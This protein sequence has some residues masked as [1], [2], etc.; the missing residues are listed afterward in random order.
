MLL[1]FIS[2]NVNGLR[3]LMKKPGWDW[4]LNA[5][6]QIIALQETKARPEQLPEEAVARPGWRIFWDFS[7]VKKGYSGVGVYSR[8]EPESAQAQLPDPAYQG[9]GRLLRI[10]YPEFHFFN[11]YFP[12]GGAEILDEDGKGTGGFKRLSYKMGFYSAFL[13]YAVQCQKTKPV[14]VCGDFNA[15]RQDIDLSDPRGNERMTGFL[16]EERAWLED[17]IAAGFVDAFR[18]MRGDIPDQ[19]TWWSYRTRARGK[20]IGWRI[21]Y[22]FVSKELAP[23]IKDACIYKDVHGSDHCPVGLSLEI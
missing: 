7:V 2:W 17:F 14:I 15:A 3:A 9:E 6:A 23:R 16:P 12:N 22:F 5:D 10:E 1:N 4:L 18:F 19:Y 11:V 13:K 8:I 21:D 20:N